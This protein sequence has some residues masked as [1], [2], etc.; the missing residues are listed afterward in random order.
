M[1]FSQ[2][3]EKQFIWSKRVIILLADSPDNKN[4]K[5]QMKIFGMEKKEMEERDLIVLT[6]HSAEIPVS[7]RMQ[8][9]Q[10]YASVNTDFTIL[11]L[12]KDGGVK[13]KKN[14]PV[15]ASELFSLIDSMPMRRS[16]MKDQKR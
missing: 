4:F 10:K 14:E 1:S 12:G 9:F 8:L 13:L 6:N 11:L 2:S 15:S 3:Y 5:T 16:E 7:D